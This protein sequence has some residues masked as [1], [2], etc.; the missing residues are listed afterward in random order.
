MNELPLKDRLTSRKF[1]L[2]TIFAIVALFGEKV[3]ITL[4]TEELMA[5]AGAIGLY[6]VGNGLGKKG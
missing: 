6:S 4:S 2:T 1:W 5:V 3:G